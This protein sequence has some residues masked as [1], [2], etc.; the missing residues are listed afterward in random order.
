MPLKSSLRLRLQLQRA[1]TDF[2]FVYIFLD[3]R[4]LKILKKKLYD[5][6]I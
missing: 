5:R 2:T 6:T 3:R 1:S 4:T